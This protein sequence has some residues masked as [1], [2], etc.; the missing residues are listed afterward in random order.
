MLL[1]W[2]QSA[3]SALEAAW[4]LGTRHLIVEAA[5]G[6]GKGTLAAAALCLLIRLYGP[7]MLVTHTLEIQTRYVKDMITTD[8]LWTRIGRAAGVRPRVVLLGS[9]TAEKLAKADIIIATVQLVS[10]RL[11]TL[12]R[13]LVRS[14]V[15]DEGACARARACAC[16]PPSPTTHAGCCPR[17]CTTGHH[18]PAASWRT[19]PQYFNDAFT[20]LLTATPYRGDRRPLHGSLVYS[21]PLPTAIHERAV[22][23]PVFM[24]VTPATL[25]TDANVRVTLDKMCESNSRAKVRRAVAASAACMTDVLRVARFELDRIRTQFPLRRHLVLVKARSVADA[26]SL[27]EL[28]NETGL[29]TLT[30]IHSKLSPEERKDNHETLDSNPAC[31]GVVVA[32]C[33]QEG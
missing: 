2:Q 23:H 14:V 21:Y 17:V 7:V 27:V 8:T 29:F 6:T 1:P 9:A 26:H 25:S 22:R 11:K 13:T 12:P 4:A 28:A 15:Y 32:E 30:I 18:E 16:M 33:C 3:L 19:I 24:E 31:D 5:T 10:R 20:L